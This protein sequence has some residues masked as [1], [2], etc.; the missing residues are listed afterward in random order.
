MININDDLELSIISCLLLKPELFNELIVKDEHFVKHQRIWKFIKAVY[1]KFG[2][3]D[4]SLMYSVCSTRSQYKLVLYIQ[5]LL[6]YEP[7]PSNFMKY[8]ERLIEQFNE[9]KKEQQI[10]NQIYDL[11]NELFTRQITLGD[12]IKKIEE[13]KKE[14]EK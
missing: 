4:I 6:D 14:I 8:Q 5:E 3:L 1:D 13:K 11:S 12:F 7:A 10:I 9:S 2:T